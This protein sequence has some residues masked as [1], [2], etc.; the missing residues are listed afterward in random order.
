M[1]DRPVVGQW[2][3]VGEVEATSALRMP[4]PRIFLRRLDV[5]API[6]SYLDTITSHPDIWDL[7]VE[8]ML[9]NDPKV[10][11][12][13][14][15]YRGH[16]TFAM[17]EAL[18]IAGKEAHIYT[19]DTDD[20]HVPDLLEQVELSAYVTCHHGPFAEMLEAVPDPIDFAF[21]DA[22]SIDNAALR[23]DCLNLVG[24]RLAP[25]GLIVVDDSTD[26][27]WQGA[28]VLRDNCALYLKVGRGLTVFQ[29]HV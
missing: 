8:L 27:G 24:P 26:D 7:L 13:A 29:K 15:T 3:G 20:H 2:H 16:A 18:R 12:E 22:S 21:I 14:G 23:I 17:A 6:L 9:A 25:W 4:M 28:K 19:A 10:I 5:W 1:M 11:V